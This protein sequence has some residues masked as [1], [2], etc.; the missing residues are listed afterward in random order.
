MKVL[1]IG[2]TGTISMAITKKLLAEGHQ[3]YLVN[4]GNRN[5]CVGILARILKLFNTVSSK[6]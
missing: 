3:V 6:R 5:G 2:G 4:R 1:F